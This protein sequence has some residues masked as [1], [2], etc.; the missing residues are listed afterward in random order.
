MRQLQTAGKERE[1]GLGNVARD[2]QSQTENEPK[3]LVEGLSLDSVL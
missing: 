2:S 1:R 3:T